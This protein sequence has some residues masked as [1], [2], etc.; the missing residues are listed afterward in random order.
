MWGCCWR[1]ERALARGTPHALD[2]LVRS[3]KVYSWPH[4]YSSEPPRQ[5]SMVGVLAA[6]MAST[7]VLGV[8]STCNEVI[9]PGELPV[10]LSTLLSYGPRSLSAAH[11]WPGVEPPRR[12]SPSSP[13]QAPSKG[14]SVL[15]WIVLL[16]RWTAMGLSSLQSWGPNSLSAVLYGPVSSSIHVHMLVTGLLL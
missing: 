14:S 15:P 6:S 2:R 3:R 16:S 5:T 13:T 8:G 9:Y 1:A 7:W 12:C 10:G 11:W 4:A